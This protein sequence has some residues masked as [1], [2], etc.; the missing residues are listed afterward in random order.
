MQ[1]E[2][3]SEGRYALRALLYLAWL[4]ERASADR[5]SAE[6]H[7][8]R[9]LLAQ[10]QRPLALEPRAQRLDR[11]IDVDHFVGAAQAYRHARTEAPATSRIVAAISSVQLYIHRCLMNLE[12]D[13]RTGGDPGRRRRAIANS[14][15]G[16]F[17][18][19]GPAAGRSPA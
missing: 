9:R 3:S 7:V 18:P 1:L 8:P 17:S 2:L 5:I 13:R 15:A 6:A 10:R 14:S 16:M 19:L 11:D 4:G 12:Q